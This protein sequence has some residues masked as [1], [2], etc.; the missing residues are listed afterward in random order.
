MGELLILLVLVQFFWIRNLD[1]QLK[2]TLKMLGQVTMV[3][4][5]LTEWSDASVTAIRDLKKNGS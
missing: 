3:Q 2:N 1:T 5:G 4:M